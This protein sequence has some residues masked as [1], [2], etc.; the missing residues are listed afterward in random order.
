MKPHGNG[1]LRPVTTMDA[2]ANTE[3][4]HSQEYE[5]MEERYSAAVP[6]SGDCLFRRPC[7]FRLIQIDSETLNPFLCILRLSPQ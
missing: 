5:R 2:L 3:K 6:G 1:F 7:Y 4:W